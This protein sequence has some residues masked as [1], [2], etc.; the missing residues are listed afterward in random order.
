MLVAHTVEGI[1]SCGRELDTYKRSLFGCVNL[2]TVQCLAN[3]T[4]KF[5]TAKTEKRV[6]DFDTLYDA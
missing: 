5:V 2:L 3:Y 1:W 4:N 6:E